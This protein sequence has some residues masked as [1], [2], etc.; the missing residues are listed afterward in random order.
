MFPVINTTSAKQN[1]RNSAVSLFG[2][3]KSEHV[4]ST[5]QTKSVLPNIVLPKLAWNEEVY[6]PVMD[7][8]N[9]ISK[10]ANILSRNELVIIYTIEKRNLKSSETTPIAC[11]EFDLLEFQQFYRD[12]VIS[13]SS[14]NINPLFNVPLFL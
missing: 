13:Q 11:G 1:N 3:K 10:G 5:K 9:I 7:V 14:I 4:D 8:S 12:Y 2:S 6:R